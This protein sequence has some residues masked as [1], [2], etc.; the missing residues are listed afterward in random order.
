MSQNEPL[1]IC[2]YFLVIGLLI[3]QI[4]LSSS[5][6]LTLQYVM[7]QQL[8]KQ[9]PWTN[10]SSLMVS[11]LKTLMTRATE[12]L[13][14]GNVNSSIQYLDIINNE[15]AL[16]LTQ[17]TSLIEGQTIKLLIEDAIQALRNN[18]STVATNFLNLSAQYIDL[19]LPDIKSD[20][21]SNKTISKGT[22]LA[23]VSNATSGGGYSIY[24]NPVVGIRIQYPSNWSVTEIAY[25]PAANNTI[26]G[27]FAKT[28]TASELGNI[29]GVSGSFVPYLD[30]YTFD[31]KNMSLS[32]I[33]NATI[34]NLVQDEN[35]IIHHSEPAILKGNQSGHMLVYD[36]TVGDEEFFRKI[37]IYTIFDSKV[38]VVTFTSQQDLFSEYQPTVKK[39]INSFE[40]LNT[41]K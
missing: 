33:I 17:N 30:I 36:T 24:N 14:S 41:T 13:R 11:T 16:S 23:N 31:S 25:N 1:K 40:Y 19:Q 4:I 15:L 27:F 7:A 8:Q 5:M 34:D 38:Y 3:G 6:N 21:N 29:S 18:D 26:V 39:M 12:N 37:Q 22:S 32:R 10:S 35:F 20:S 9:Q 28:K 2:R